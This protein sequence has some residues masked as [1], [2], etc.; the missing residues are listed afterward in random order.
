MNMNLLHS[1]ALLTSNE[2][3]LKEFQDYLGDKLTMKK[4][5]D[6][7]EVA[8]DSDTVSLYK[9]LE[10]GAQTI[11]EDTILTIDGEEVVDIRYKLSSLK[12][13]S[14]T[15]TALWQVMLAYNDGNYI[16]LFKGTTEG[17]L[18]AITDIPKDAF[19]FDPNFYP[20]GEDESLY[21]LNQKGRKKDVSARC[22]ALALLT[23]GQYFKRVKIADIPKWEGNYQQ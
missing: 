17:V 14:S 19:G 16:Y 10:A 15:P 12:G 23:K 20:T 2:N 18:R 6:I 3:K 1:A 21:A 13:M 8:A 22:K 7:K 5:K 4:G 11:T 9:S